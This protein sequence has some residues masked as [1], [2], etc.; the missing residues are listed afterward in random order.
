M[1]LFSRRGG[2]LAALLVCAAKAGAQTA[3]P[4]R[5]DTTSCLARSASTVA[6]PSRGRADSSASARTS[7]DSTRSPVAVVLYAEASAKEITFVR[8]PELRVRLCG[9]LDSVHVVERT[10][11]PSP[12]VSGTTY[13][14]VHVAVEIFGRLNADC[15]T[16]ALT[17]GP[18]PSNT[19]AGACASLELNNSPS[20]KRPPFK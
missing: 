1:T 15:I 20:V 4:L 12:V 3:A 19:P 8:Q 6:P 17:H 7:A 5:V 10:N 18:L 16:A 13:R 9:G 11:L 2:V 14:D